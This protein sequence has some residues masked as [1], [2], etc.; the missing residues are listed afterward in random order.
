MSCV[1]ADGWCLS[2]FLI[3]ALRVGFC[4]GRVAVDFFAYFVLGR[5]VGSELVST[6]TCRF[7]STGD[8]A[9]G[10]HGGFCFL[11]DLMNSPGLWF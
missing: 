8:S 2:P 11:A 4:A 5:F 3:F 9:F 10:D 1:A 7:E 6:A